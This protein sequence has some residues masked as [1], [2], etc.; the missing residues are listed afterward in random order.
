MKNT[1]KLPFLVALFFTLP[2][3]CLFHYT[4]AVAGDTTDEL[5]N[6]MIDGA[7]RAAQVFSDNDLEGYLSYTT[8]DFVHESVSRP[9]GTREQFA[10][11]I[12]NFFKSFPGVKNYQVDLLPYENYLVFDECTFEI[13]LPGTDKKSRPSTWT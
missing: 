11:K 12:D 13:P 4:Q 2:F 1:A 9:P 7:H 6:E 5:I 10:K 3:Y 8:E